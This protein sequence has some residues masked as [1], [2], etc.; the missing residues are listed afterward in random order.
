MGEILKMSREITYKNLVY[1]TSSISFAK[2]GG[3]VYTYDDLKKGNKTL[4]QVQKQ[5][6]KLNQ[7]L[8]I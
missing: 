2:F 7:S 6:K 1:P 5:Q 8:V 4:Q 3:P